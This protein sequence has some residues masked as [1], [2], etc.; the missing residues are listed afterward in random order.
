MDAKKEYFCLQKTKKL[1]LFRSYELLLLGCER[2]FNHIQLF[3]NLKL[4]IF[5]LFLIE[6]G[7]YR[8]NKIIGMS[9]PEKALF[10]NFYDEHS[11]SD[12]RFIGQ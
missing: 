2:N 11:I 9:L 7:A 6:E 5:Q 1:P 3:Y 10:R 4:T 8:E 12:H